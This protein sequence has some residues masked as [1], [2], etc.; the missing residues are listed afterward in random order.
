MHQ[1]H[2]K[3]DRI[4]EAC[5][6]IQQALNEHLN[7]TTN[8]KYKAEIEKDL[9]T[10]DNIKHVVAAVRS[11]IDSDKIGASTELLLRIAANDFRNK[12]K[13]I[14][15]KKTTIREIVQAVNEIHKFILRTPSHPVA[16][17]SDKSHSCLSAC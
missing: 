3:L 11:D 4:N 6:E 2:G 5:G 16:N 13:L 7:A 14:P 9:V 12:L 8:P 17:R 10:L 1:I 15:E